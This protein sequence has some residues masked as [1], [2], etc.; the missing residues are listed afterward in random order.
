[1]NDHDSICSTMSEMSVQY[2]GN[3]VD[4]ETAVDDIFKQLGDHINQCH[5]EIRNMCSLVE[6]GDDYENI[7]E[8][9]MEMKTHIQEGS[10]VFK[11]LVK[12]MKQVIGKPPK[13]WI[14]PEK[15]TLGSVP[16]ES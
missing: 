14:A 3:E 12:V 15:R 1:M 7:Y 16:E 9:Y 13:G 4:L 11:D 8:Y 5:V 6:R 10:L 2:D